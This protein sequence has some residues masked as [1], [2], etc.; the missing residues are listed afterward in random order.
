MPFAAEGGW[1]YCWLDETI[2]L[3]RCRTYNWR[4]QQFFGSR[5]SEGD[6]VFLP[7]DGGPAMATPDLVID[8]FRTGPDE[9][10]LVNGRILLARGNFERLHRIVAEKQN[11]YPRMPADH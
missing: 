8:P 1:A 11:A 9:V 4:G 3:N 5:L 10:W 6:D 2:H 7:F